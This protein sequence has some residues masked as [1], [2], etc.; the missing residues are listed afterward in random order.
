MKNTRTTSTIPAKALRREVSRKEPPL[1]TSKFSL[2]FS[3]SCIPAYH[4]Q[5][6]Y[7]HYLHTQKISHFV[8]SLHANKPSTSCVRIACP[9]FSTSLEQDVNNNLVDIISTLNVYINKTSPYKLLAF[10]ECEL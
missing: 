9:K 2:Y 5:S 8:A 4:Y 3:S 10:W 7:W 6:Y 1:K